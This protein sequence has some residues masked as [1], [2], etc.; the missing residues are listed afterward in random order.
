MSIV[1][2]IKMWITTL[3]VDCQRYTWQHQT[4]TSFHLCLSLHGHMWCCRKSVKLTNIKPNWNPNLVLR[5][6]WKQAWQPRL[7]FFCKAL[8]HLGT[9]S[10]VHELSASVC[11]SRQQGDGRVVHNGQCF[12]SSGWRRQTS[13]WCTHS[14]RQLRR[15]TQVN[16]HSCCGT[17]AG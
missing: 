9:S 4:N 2:E 7:P 10:E 12:I 11:V 8:H 5:H 17:V 6:L 14:M 16:T 13:A 3:F 15:Q 1:T